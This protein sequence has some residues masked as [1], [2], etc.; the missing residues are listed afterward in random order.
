MGDF[1]LTALLDELSTPQYYDR[2]IQNGFD[3]WDDVL[4][5]TEADMYLHLSHQDI[6][7]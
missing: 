3:S 4:D 6:T 2:F 7:I 1:N 5:I